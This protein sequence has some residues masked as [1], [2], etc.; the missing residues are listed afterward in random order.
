M[1]DLSPQFFS[2]GNHLLE[3]ATTF[4]VFIRHCADEFSGGKRRLWGEVDHSNSAVA[5]RLHTQR[6]RDENGTKRWPSLV[7]LCT[8]RLPNTPPSIHLT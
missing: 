8:H 5:W 4:L 1:Q 6:I 2:T 7:R 3:E